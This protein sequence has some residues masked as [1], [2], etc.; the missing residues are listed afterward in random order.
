VKVTST[1]PV[2]ADVYSTLMSELVHGAVEPLAVAS[3]A[4][5]PVPAALTGLASVGT[6]GEKSSV[7]AADAIAGSAAN[8]TAATAAASSVSSLDTLCLSWRFR[9]LAGTGRPH[10]QSQVATSQIRKCVAPRPRGVESPATDVP[11]KKGG[12]RTAV[13]PSF[14]RSFHLV[15]PMQIPAYR[16]VSCAVS[17]SGRVVVP[18][19][20]CDD[21]PAVPPLNDDSRWN[22]VVLPSISWY[23]WTPADDCSKLI[24]DDAE[25]APHAGLST[26]P[27]SP[28]PV[29]LTWT[30]AVHSNS[31]N[32]PAGLVGGV[33]NT[34]VVCVNPLMYTR[35]NR[36]EFVVIAPAAWPEVLQLNPEEVH[37]VNCTTR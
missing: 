1:S 24:V 30:R 17:F 16:H 6:V 11:P 13:L 32:T 5:P 7:G 27:M 20:T 4:L 18:E 22:L 15:L 26:C 21:S 29:T 35:W 28:L 25:V 19:V 9:P 37:P 36:D 33:T 34:P 10:A 8:A 31:A 12:P 3:V 2:V 14:C 23:F